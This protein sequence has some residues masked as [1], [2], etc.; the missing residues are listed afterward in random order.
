MPILFAL[1][2]LVFLFSACIVEA[3]ETAKVLPG[4]IRRARV[5]G[6][7]TGNVEKTFNEDGELQGLSHSLNRTV[8]IGDLASNADAK[9]KAQLNSLI[10]SLNTLSPG[11]GNQLAASDLSSKF[12][13]NVQMYMAAFEYGVTDRVTVGIRM[14]IVKRNVTNRFSVS[15]I[16]N[17]DS[18]NAQLG[19]LSPQ[20]TSGLNGIS[21]K[22]L[23]TAFFE[24]ALFTSKGYEAPHDFQDTSV[25]DLEFGTKYNFY[26]SDFSASSILIGAR[27][28]TGSKASLTNPFDKGTGKESWGIAAQVFEEF[29]PTR[30]ITVG[31]AAKIGHSFSD[32]RDRAIP[33]NETDSLPSLLPQD[34][35]VQ[36]TTRQTGECLETELSAGYRFPG[37]AWGL[38]SAYQYSKKGKDKFTGPGNLYYEGLA[39]NT[40]YTIHAGELGAEYSTIQAYRNGKFAV[41]MDI[42][43]TYNSVLRGENTPKA[44]YARLD[45]M[46]YF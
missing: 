34:G 15:T 43:L 18:I 25:G 12:S 4:G 28:P 24:N 41:P 36:K 46:L 22:Q 37:N 17:A 2:A 40:N 44:A 29:Y 30:G 16:N 26:K 31:G 32:T 10:S 5:V 8:T 7:M 14:P 20:V 3:K 35:Q 11:L 45:L 1:S 42:S 13:Q 27:A 19:G 38:W 21:N 33:K 23:D 9:T 39:K 6:V